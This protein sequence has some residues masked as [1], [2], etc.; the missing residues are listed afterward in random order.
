[1]GKFKN[2]V[3]M[4]VTKGQFESLIVDLE[5]IGYKNKMFKFGDGPGLM[6]NNWLRNTASIFAINKDT[7]LKSDWVVVNPYNPDLFLALCAQSDTGEKLN[8]GEWVMGI[9]GGFKQVVKA[10]GLLGNL[11]ELN[12]GTTSYLMSLGKP[13]VEALTKHFTR[14]AV[15]AQAM[16]AIRNEIKHLRSSDHVHGILLH[17]PGRKPLEVLRVNGKVASNLAHVHERPV[18]FADAYWNATKQKTTGDIP[19]LKQSILSKASTFDIY[20]DGI[21]QKEGGDNF[22][23]WKAIGESVKGISTDGADALNMAIS[24]ARAE[25]DKVLKPGSLEDLKAR[26][27]SLIAFQVDLEGVVK[28]GIELRLNGL[29]SEAQKLVDIVKKRIAAVRGIIKQMED[30]AMRDNVPPVVKSDEPQHRRNAIDVLEDCL[31]AL[32]KIHET[33]KQMHG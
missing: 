16:E 31:V 18:D 27:L 7:E 23:K 3:A 30:K 13:S 14:K 22:D 5:S 24:T 26:L 17:I 33:Q 8:V 25:Q 29:S 1:M 21:K 28:D 11:Y 10:G 12:D 6:V 2:K 9:N 19:T 20:I 32:N 15:A 4:L